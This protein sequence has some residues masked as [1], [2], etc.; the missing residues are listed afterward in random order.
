LGFVLYRLDLVEESVNAFQTA[1]ALQ[2]D[3]AEAHG[4]L[5]V[6]YGRLGLTELAAQEI[7]TELSLRAA[8]H[9]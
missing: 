8:G 6:A 2:P 1:I 3:F 5:A 7:R 4:N 9:R